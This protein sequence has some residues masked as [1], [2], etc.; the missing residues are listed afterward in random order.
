MGSMYPLEADGLTALRRVE[1]G[2]R[3]RQQ[4]LS[5]GELAPQFCLPDADMTLFDLAEY[6]GRNL[7]VLHFY[8]RDAMPSC[9][10]IVIGFSDLD[11]AFT[12][13]GA[14][15]VGISLDACEAHAAFRDEHGVATRLLADEDGEICRLY[16]L[17]HGREE[18]GTART[19]VQRSSYI[20]GRDGMVLR[21]MTET[22]GD[23]P[24][25][26]LPAAVLAQVREL[27]GSRNGN[28]Q[29]Q[30]RHPQARG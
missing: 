12:R 23:M 16:G 25:A 22:T 18:G 9:K 20:I 21:A 4:P 7:V 15:V 17:W 10:R 2:L 19:A 3:S 1:S 27:S 30:R 6:K 14:V 13:C 26:E 28:R 24:A 29:E 11:E 5:E 8:P